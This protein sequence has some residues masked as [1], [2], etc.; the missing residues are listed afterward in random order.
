MKL[1][2]LAAAAILAVATLA[3]QLP[4][5]AAVPY[6]M[7]RPAPTP[8]RSAKMTVPSTGVPTGIAVT[9]A[10]QYLIGAQHAAF[11]GLTP[12]DGGGQ[13][14]TYRQAGG[15]EVRDGK[16]MVT[17]LDDYGQDPSPAEALPLAPADYRDP[18]P[19]EIDGEVYTTFFTGTAAQPAQGAFV[20]LPSG[21]VRRIDPGFG[22]AAISAPVVKLPNGTLGAVWYGN[23]VNGGQDDAYLSISK[24]GGLDWEPPN[25]I[26][27][28]ASEGT[29]EPWLVVSGTKV[30]LLARWGWNRLA[31]IASTNSGLPGSWGT[32]YLVSST[33]AMT[34]RPTTYRTPSGVLVMSYRTLPAKDARLAYSLDN[35]VTWKIGPTLMKAPA[36]SPN[37]MTYTAFGPVK[38]MPGVT[39]V[40]VGMEKADDT[41]AL[42]ATTIAETVAV[43]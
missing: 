25:R 17:T 9:A 19:A 8:I 37:G 36:G 18:S 31:A 12:V 22:R 14:L 42:Y 21:E 43:S 5:A 29:P 35:G 11:P 15:H 34:G 28:P 24:N 39:R 6:E 23:P 2:T 33:E 3:A 20:R 1:T 41:S 32:P 7:P 16:I 13:I 40:I 27:N 30:L 4:G 38:G 26:L 10:P